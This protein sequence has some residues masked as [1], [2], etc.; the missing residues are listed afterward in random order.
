MGVIIGSGVAFGIGPPGTV[1]AGFSCGP[2]TSSSI[3]YLIVAGG[4]GGGAGSG[5]GGG[6]GGVLSGSLCASPN[7]TY[8]ITVGCKGNGGS[9]PGG[10]YN[11]GNNGTASSL[12]IPSG[13][14][15]SVALNGSNQYLTVPYSTTNFN[16]YTTDYTIEAWIYPT[17]YK[18]DGLPAAVLVGNMDATGG[19]NYWSFGINSNTGRIGFYYYNGS[20][21][22]VNSTDTVPLNAWSQI[23]MTKTASGITLFVN[24]VS[25]GTTAINGSP[26]SSTGLPLTI[27]AYNNQYFAGYVS[28]LRIVKGTAVYTGNYTPSKTLTAIPNTQLLTFQSATTITDASTNAYT[29]TT[30]NSASA[31]YQSPS[32]TTVTAVGGGGGSGDAYNGPSHFGQPGGSGGG[33]GG[34]TNTVNPRSPVGLATGSPGFGVA[35][36]Q[37][38]PGG[39]A[40]NPGSPGTGGGGGGA[41][42]TGGC[43]TS[44]LGG[45]GGN[46]IK[47]QI[48]GVCTYYGCGGGGA[49]NGGSYS[50]GGIGGGGGHGGPGCGRAATGFGGGGGGGRGGGGN[51]GPG[52]PG[53][54]IMS[55]PT[56]CFSANVSGTYNISTA[57]SNTIVQFTGNGTYT[58]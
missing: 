20:Q 24:G 36:S 35:G 46:G 32:A 41:G 54:V 44:C 57:G 5:G 42:S 50:P 47:S 26:Q 6:A 55:I 58:A 30:H 38:Y 43:A 34:A 31:S 33:G 28:N 9:A 51:G 53:T 37:G 21:Q 10:A 1:G 12:L 23:A 48:T 13:T 4:G 52:Y 7:T 25:Q 27:G 49:T 22:F 16:W 3:Q 2:V 56:T 8:T 40:Y 17:A 14:L 18:Y 39:Y 29:I 45:P 11:N 19:T 15:G